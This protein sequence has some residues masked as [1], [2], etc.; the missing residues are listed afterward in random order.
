MDIRLKPDDP[1]LELPMT[2]AYLRWALQAVEEV[3]GDKGMR[4]ILRQAGLEHLIGNYPPNQMV[5]TGHTFK[6]YADLNRAILE[7][8]GR[9]GASFVRRIGR[10]SARRSI[11]EQ[12]RLFGLGRLALKLM[13]TNVQ[14]KMG[15]ISMAHGFKTLYKEAGIE[16]EHQ[17]EEH[18]DHFLY[19]IVHCP[20]CAG[21]EADRPICGMWLGALYEGGL[22]ITGGKVFE[23]REI[24]CR[25]LGD[26]A[27]VF[28]ISKTPISG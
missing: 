7:F 9:A 11:E 25:A 8:Y 12:D 15:L 17:V 4:V 14:L 28:W 19:S 16:V 22:Y 1:M 24:A 20:C 10:L 13:S 2:D 5:F 23:Y 27:C 6:E 21:M 3:A 18:E 26:P